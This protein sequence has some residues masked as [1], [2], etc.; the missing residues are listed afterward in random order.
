VLEGVSVGHLA[1]EEHADR[2]E[3]RMML[4]APHAQGRGIG[5]SL[6]RKVMERAKSRRL[7][8]ALWVTD[9]NEGAIRF[10]RRFGFE[11]IDML[12]GLRRKLESCEW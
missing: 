4:L 9:W 2:I 7:P 11:I 10:Y 3:L 5:S 6:M 8:V 1:V 12:N